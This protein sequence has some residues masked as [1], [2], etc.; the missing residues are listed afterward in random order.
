MMVHNADG[1]VRGTI[2]LQFTA[3]EGDINTIA[4][5]LELVLQTFDFHLMNGFFVQVDV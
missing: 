5:I 2:Q 3:F 4:L 1:L